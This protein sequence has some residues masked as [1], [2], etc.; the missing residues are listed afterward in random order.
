MEGERR[1]RRVY[2]TVS[3][4]EVVGPTDVDLKYVPPSLRVLICER[5][6]RH[7]SVVERVELMT[8]WTQRR[9]FI[10]GAD[11]TSIRNED[12]QTCKVCYSRRDRL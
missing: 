5:Y 9:T 11:N 1:R 3:L 7:H 6:G 12:V 8:R 4:D 2:G 10:R